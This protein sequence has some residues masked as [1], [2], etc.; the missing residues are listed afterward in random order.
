MDVTFWASA[1]AYKNAHNRRHKSIL[2]VPLPPNIKKLEK[3]I[4]VRGR[5]Y[6]EYQLGL[7]SDERYAMD[8]YPGAARL[9][10]LCGWSDANRRDLQSRRTG[11]A[12]RNFVCHQG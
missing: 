5:W 9:N 1:S 8:L 7:V 2:C 4:D 6:T 3:K 12:A 10:A 11:G